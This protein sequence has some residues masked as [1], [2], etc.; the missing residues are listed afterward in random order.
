MC[1]DGQPRTFSTDVMCVLADTHGRP[2]CTEQTAHDQRA[3]MFTDG[4]SRTHTR[5]TTDVLC[6][7][8]DTHG[9]PRTQPTWA[10]ITR[11][12][13]GK[14]QRAESKD[15]R[16]D[17]QP[18]WAKITR[19][20]HGKGQ[21]AE[22]KDQRAD[23][24]T[25]G[26][27]RT[28]YSPRGPKSPKQ[29]TGRVSLLSPRTN[30][31]IC[32][33]MD[34]HRRPVF[35]DGHTRTH[36]D[37]HR[38]PV[39]PT[40]A[41]ITQTVHGKG[42]PAESKDQRADMCT[43][44]QPQTSCVRTAM[45]ALC[46]LVDTLGRPVCA[47]GHPQTSCV[48]TPTDVLC[49]QNR[50]P[51]WAKNT[52]T[53]HGKG[54]RAESKDQ[55]ADMCTDGQP[56]TSCVQTWTATDVLCV[57]T[58]THGRHVCAG[59]HPRMSYVLCVLT[60]PT[61]VLCVLNR[62]P[63]WAKITRTVHR[64]G[65]R[66]EFKDQRADM[67]TD[68]QPQTSYSPRGAKSPEQSTGRVSVLSPRTNVLICV[69]MDSHRRPVCADGHTRT[70]TDSHGPMDVLCVMT[71]THGRPVQPTWAKITQTVHRKGQ[72]AESKDQRADMC[73]DG[74]PQ[75]SCSTGR[76][77]VLSP[78]TSVLI[79][80]LMDSHRRPV[81]ADGHTRTATDILPRG[82]KSPKQSTGR[83]SLLSPRTNVLICVLM[84][85]H[86]RPVCANGHTRT[87]TDS[88]RRPVCADGHPR[89]SCVF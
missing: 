1:T 11:T 72:R 10:K 29:S 30:V 65:Q 71:D 16:A 54:Q 49:V 27:P 28:S 2:V 26:Q 34:S 50:Q 18:T 23:M 73:T 62:Q 77:S 4:Q 48:W 42:Q 41:K 87:H 81:C 79:C 45:D 83:V 6:V 64:K 53:V 47:D 38:R 52:R 20:V 69:L 80:V 15:Q 36:T 37:S 57:L 66:A 24:C 32:V 85:S 63:T 12:V 84:D 74:Q 35:A 68:G 43:D 56:H 8:T 55:R 17:I 70:H 5:T 22:S 61:D 60:A 7:L 82:R 51:T 3:D 39:Q 25:D 13:H 86:R 9:Q 46:V 21:R 58:D 67:C 78:R 44:G 75:T 76:A 89:T 14:G 33:L 88:H 31:L 19:T 59:G 40:W